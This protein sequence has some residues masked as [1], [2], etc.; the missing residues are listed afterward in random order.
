[1][2][3]SKKIVCLS[4]LLIMIT[5]LS[6]SQNINSVSDSAVAT[7]RE[8]RLF[9]KPLSGVDARKVLDCVEPVKHFHFK[10]VT[11]ECCIV[12]LGILED[13]FGIFF[14]IMLTLTCKLLGIIT[15]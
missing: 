11:E 12:L 6:I 9:P 7:R 4:I 1:M 2:S 13:C 14:P 5:I 10:N 8:K 3:G 15:V